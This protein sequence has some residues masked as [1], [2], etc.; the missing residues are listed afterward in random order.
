MSSALVKAECISHDER[1]IPASP[2][3]SAVIDVAR[4]LGADINKLLRGTGLFENTL[5]EKDYISARQFESL[6]LNAHKQVR[7]KD[8]TF[9]VGQALASSHY[10]GLIRALR[11]AKN[12]SHAF[13][14]LS[15]FL[16]PVCPLISVSHYRQQNTL[17]YLFRDG[18][19]KSKAFSLASEVVMAC[20]IALTKKWCGHRLPIQFHFTNAR[21]RYIAN[22][23]MHLGRRLC[24][25]Q[26]F[27]GFSINQ[28]VMQTTFKHA[29]SFLL[30]A[31]VC[32]YKK[33]L[34]VGQLL[35]DVIRGFVTRNAQSSI[36]D[37]AEALH[38]SPATLKRKLK[39]YN[40]TFTWLSDEVKRE[41]VIF[42]LQVCQLSNEQSAL[43][44]AIT[45]LTNFR[46]AVKRWTGNTPSELRGR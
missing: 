41:Q 39:G 27:T 43:K 34:K 24:F 22:Y 8:F 31:S 42:L 26:S 16:L 38:V 44:M 7:A 14:V 33:H 18:M 15:V 4:A 20:L 45:D 28:D 2:L 6:L 1:A 19:G 13:T 40:V 36:T 37:V 5:T 10:A 30:R 11:Y 32:H 3:C 9:Q 21:P 12:T 17:F 35:P 23:E 29:D 46:R 25:E